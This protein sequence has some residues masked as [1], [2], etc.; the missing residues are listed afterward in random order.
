M[1]KKLKSLLPFTKKASSTDTSSPNKPS[2]VSESSTWCRSIYDTPLYK[3]IE[4][5]C[6]GNK[7]ALIISG[8]P[9]AEQLD[10]A[11]NDIAREYAEKLGSTE[12]K[13]FLS[14]IKDITELKTTLYQIEML[15][16]TLR[17]TYALPF[18]KMLNRISRTNYPF[19]PEDSEKYDKSLNS[20][21]MRSKGLMLTLKLKEIQLDSLQAKFEKKEGAGPD[22]GYFENALITLSDHAHFHLNDRIMTSEF[23]L[24]LKNYTDHIESQKRK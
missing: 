22:R 1:P 20:C 7:S 23:C 2:D 3:F 13:L 10:D 19:N 15:V 16:E 9:A 18:A 21:L 4:V 6:D 8:F 5:I 24:R 14:L 12:H 11:W 17:K